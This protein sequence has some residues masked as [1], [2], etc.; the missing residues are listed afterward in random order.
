MPT[1]RYNPAPNVDPTLQPTDSF[2]NIQATPGMFGAN[3]G[4]EL[5]RFGSQL[6]AA[7]NQLFAGAMARQE[8]LNQV[9]ADDAYNQV[10][11][12]SNKLLYG[13][14]NTPGDV[15]FYGA[16]GKDAMN[17]F[18]KVRQ[19]LDDFVNQAR[20][21][22]QNPQQQHLFENTSRRFRSILFA[23]MGRHYDR[24]LDNYALNTAKA[25]EKLGEFGMATAAASGNDTAFQDALGKTMTSAAAAAQLQGL[26]TEGIDL[27][28]KQAGSKA[29]RVW[30]DSVGLKDPIAALDFLERH[31]DM[32][33]P[34]E[35]P[36]IVKEFQGKAVQYQAMVDNGLAPPLQSRGPNL[37]RGGAVDESVAQQLVDTFKQRGWSDAAIT[38]T[39][40]NVLT[41]SSLNLNA[42]GEA[43]EEGLFQFHPKTHL[44][45]FLGA[46]KGDRSPAAQANYVADVIEKTMP[47]FAQITDSDQ[48]TARFM[49]E[50][51]R[52]RDQSDAALRGR[53]SNTGVSKPLVSMQRAT[54]PIANADTLVAPPRDEG[55][56]PDETFPG[57]SEKIQ[58]FVKKYADNPLQMIASIK[59]AR[60]QANQAY[61]DAQHQLRIKQQAQKAQDQQIEQN[62]IG[63]MTADSPNYPTTDEVN[64][65]VGQGKL[66]AESG[67]TMV[68]FIE[69]Q[70]KPDPLAHI[71]ARN[72]QELYGR[73]HAD[74]TDPQKIYDKKPIR[75]AY[76]AGNL[77]WSAR[78]EL[79][80][81]FDKLQGSREKDL[82]KAE[83]D[84]LKTIEPKI[85]PELAMFGKEKAN[86]LAAAKPVAGQKTGPERLQAW[87][88]AVNQKMRDYEKANKN[89]RD[90]FNPASP[91]WVGS[92]DFLKPYRGTLNMQLGDKTAPA[93]F[94][95]TTADLSA[96]QRAV[97]AGTITRDQAIAEAV[98]RGLVRAPV[99]EAQ[100]PLAR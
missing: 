49:R 44:P 89:P 68:G 1:L 4:A 90:L 8:F 94:D 100:A 3:R 10:Q 5:E 98:K 25:S 2:Q 54:V 46:Y 7:S 59:L 72:Q 24:E 96:L 91:D 88:D 38:G 66:T 34:G 12:F 83:N 40:N 56:L 33:A 92:E 80:A 95:I 75:D 81:D 86:I 62:L 41:E 42:K 60:Q 57:L 43:G 76:I 78:S 17:M 37:V 55:E 19:Q 20:K 77:T 16:K 39:L 27:A 67:R 79:E 23:E 15:G 47:G 99:P 31:K 85:W 9:A 50:F 70:T 52:P 65:L 11:D 13:D 36:A 61:A 73:I 22:M 63:R 51:E 48:A 28:K 32:V 14:P 64:R 84:L 97:T 6:G 53:I 26:G 69:R 82:A 74:D 30:A 45:A 58:G 21:G 71:S 87:K 93:A 18:P 35:Y 29:V